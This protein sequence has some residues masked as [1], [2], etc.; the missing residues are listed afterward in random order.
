MSQHG[1]LRGEGRPMVA[2]PGG[3]SSSRPMVAPPGGQLSSRPMQAPMPKNFKDISD[4]HIWKSASEDFQSVVRQII[5][6][7]VKKLAREK[8]QS[9]YRDKKKME[10]IVSKL[11]N[12]VM[13]KECKRFEQGQ[14]HVTL[15][16]ELVNKVD[17]YTRNHLK[18]YTGGGGS[19][20]K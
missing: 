11:H 18:A 20:K 13:Q 7:R 10:T 1:P 5:D 17:H 6:Y 19:T 4:A 15:H 9:L 16:S 2:P 12:R 8:A 3:Q 14:S